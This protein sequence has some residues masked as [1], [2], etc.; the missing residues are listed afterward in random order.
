MIYFSNPPRKYYDLPEGYEF[1]EGDYTITGLEGKEEK[2]SKEILSL[3]EIPEKEAQK[4]LYKGLNQSIHQLVTAVESKITVEQTPSTSATESVEDGKEPNEQKST[5]QTQTDE[6]AT[7]IDYLD[8][9]FISDKIKEGCEFIEDLIDTF[10]IVWNAIANDDDDDDEINNAKDTKTKMRFMRA[11]LEEKGVDLD[12]DFEEI[13]EQLNAKYKD[14]NTEK[15]FTESV[16]KFGAELEK[17]K[18]DL[19]DFF[20]KLG[21]T[22]SEK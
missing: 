20:S 3:Y 10:E 21:D 2:T 19:F 11:R 15:E 12:D 14:K 7:E 22:T 8:F 4:H 6:A 18:D 13:P 1:I 16:E 17:I 9:S 5:E